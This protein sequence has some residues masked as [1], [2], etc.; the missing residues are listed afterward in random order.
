MRKIAQSVCCLDDVD[1]A[2]DDVSCFCSFVD[3]LAKGNMIA[4]A[5]LSGAFMGALRAVNESAVGAAIVGLWE[6]ADY[7]CTSVDLSRLQLW[8]VWRSLHHERKPNWRMLLYAILH[9]KSEDAP[10]GLTVLYVTLGV[11]VASLVSRGVATMEWL[12]IVATVALVAHFR[13]RG[14]SLPW[15]LVI[16][17]CGVGLMISLVALL[18]S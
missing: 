10:M 17:I 15:W 8:N 9:V 18:L 1:F 2:D 5:I 3:D 7:I 13:I 16:G 14:P 4:A 12:P 11:V 6:G